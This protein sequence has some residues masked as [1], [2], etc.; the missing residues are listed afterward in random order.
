MGGDSVHLHKLLGE[1]QFFLRESFVLAAKR[2]SG[3]FR[4]HPFVAVSGNL[5]RKLKILRDVLSSHEQEMYPTTPL[6]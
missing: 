4:Y 6:D 1:Q 5:G 3:N 2:T